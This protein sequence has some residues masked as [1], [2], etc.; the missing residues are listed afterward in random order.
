MFEPVDKVLEQMAAFAKEANIDAFTVRISQK[1]PG[2]V[3]PVT[4]ATFQNVTLEQVSNAESWVSR[5]FGGGEYMVAS[6]HTSNVGRRF[7]FSIGVAGQPLP[8]PNQEAITAADWTGPTQLTQL[9]GASQGNG[10]AGYMQSAPT[11]QFQF[12]QPQ[13]PAQTFAGPNAIPSTGAGVAAVTATSVNEAERLLLVQREETRARSELAEAKAQLQ[14]QQTEAKLRREFE[15]QQA[16][17]RA[18]LAAQRKPDAPP[19]DPMQGVTALM[20]ALA[21]IAATLI[22]SNNEARRAALEMQQRQAEAQ[23]QAQREMTALLLK[24][25][26]R[27]SSSPEMTAMLE[28]TKAQTEAQGSMMARIVD[29]MSVVSKTSVSMIETIAEISAPPEGSPVLDAVKEGTKALMALAG[30]AEA[31]ARK[32]IKANQQLPSG[33]QQAQAQRRAPTPEEMAQAQA[34]A[35]QQQRVAQVQA[36]QAQTAQQTQQAQVVPFPPQAKVPAQ[37]VVEAQ[38]EVRPNMPQAFDD[39]PGGFDG[40][41]TKTTVDQLEALIR[42]EHEPVEAVVQFFFDSINDPAMR[43]ELIKH[44]G[45][46]SSL[47]A[48]RLGLPWVL[49]HQEY[50]ERLGAALQRMG[51]EQGIIAPDDADDADDADDEEVA[52]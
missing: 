37:A 45:D 43:A 23:A 44:G 47:V 35:V 24:I 38:P 29:A 31:G 50:V 40:V 20:A 14:Q 17:L 30:G 3:V 9:Q 41:Q 11:Q 1:R 49:A 42:E 12:Q 34:R 51:V 33:A 2:T 48:E 8:V 26:E 19:V 28:M 46:P 25:T 7:V 4:L 27:P 39:L 32:S 36:Q 16:K 10:G 22:Q 6:N 5:L 21:P 13:R 18:E 52:S 15:E